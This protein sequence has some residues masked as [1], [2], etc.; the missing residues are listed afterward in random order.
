MARNSLEV[1][2]LVRFLTEEDMC[3]AIVVVHIAIYI[4]Y[5]IY[6]R[7]Y[8]YVSEFTRCQWKVV[9]VDINKK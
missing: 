9:D 8:M 2:Y 4:I 7:S 1:A 5:D 3:I 6:K